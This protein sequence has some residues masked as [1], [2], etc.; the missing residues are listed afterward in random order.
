MKGDF[1]RPFWNRLRR[2]SL[3]DHHLGLARGNR[4]APLVDRGHGDHS[5]DGLPSRVM[6]FDDLA[7]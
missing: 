1:G 7:G 5:E 3:W 6:N 4:L 2:R